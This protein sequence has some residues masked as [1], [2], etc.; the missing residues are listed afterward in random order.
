[1]RT[2]ILGSLNRYF[3]KTQYK[4]THTHINHG[5]IGILLRKKWLLHLCLYVVYFYVVEEANLKKENE[6]I[7][8]IPKSQPRRLNITTYQKLLQVCIGFVRILSIIYDYY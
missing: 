7:L 5:I 2:K 3:F 4:I 8:G 6:T 1:M